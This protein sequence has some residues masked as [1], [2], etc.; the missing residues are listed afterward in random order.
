MFEDRPVKW[1]VPEDDRLFDRCVLF[2]GLPLGEAVK[3][4]LSAC[5]R[6]WVHRILKGFVCSDCLV[7]RLPVLQCIEFV[8][9]FR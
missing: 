2:D 3:R 7:M 8:Q 1:I 4:L 9:G 6:K 5:S